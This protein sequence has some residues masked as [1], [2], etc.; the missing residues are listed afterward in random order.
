MSSNSKWAIHLQIST[1]LFIWHLL[2]NSTHYCV[3][4][5]KPLPSCTL[6]SAHKRTGDDSLLCQSL[7]HT[8]TNLVFGERKIHIPTCTYSVFSFIAHLCLSVTEIYMHTRCS[9]SLLPPFLFFTE[10]V[11]R[12]S[13]LQSCS[14]LVK[15]NMNS[16][17]CSGVLNVCALLC[18]R[19]QMW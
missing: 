12:C 2:L 11:K 4:S 5:D 19:K 8:H 10:A 14:P 1:A 9:F 7:S 6:T 16:A 15:N 3:F 17:H 18:G 13:F